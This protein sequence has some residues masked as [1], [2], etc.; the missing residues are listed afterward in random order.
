MPT[1]LGFVKG[2]TA[3]DFKNLPV[4]QFDM[5]SLGVNNPPSLI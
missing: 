5:S 1:P 3:R 2:A 4:G